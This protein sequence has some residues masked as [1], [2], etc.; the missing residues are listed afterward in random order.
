MKTK[1]IIMSLFVLLST[2]GHGSE[3]KAIKTIKKLG[4]SL[5]TELKN[6]MKISSQEAMKVCNTQADKIT[7][8]SNTDL[9]K[10]GRVSEK[11][12]NPQSFPKKWMVD[13][14]KKLKAGKVKKP[15]IVVKVS[16][17]KMGLLKSISTQP[18]CLKCHGSNINPQVLKQIT[19][20]YPEDKAVGYKLGDI[21]GY[22]WA[23][24]ELK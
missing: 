21:R 15:Y 7:I 3:V 9:I 17:N 8:A 12:R 4:M 24:W 19:S 10:V 11:N 20:L 14:I 5:K 22:F 2:S 23:E 1:I 18:V 13:G 16:S 6:A